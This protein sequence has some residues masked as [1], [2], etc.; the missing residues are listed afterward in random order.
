M[1]IPQTLL[2]MKA[3]YH[4]FNTEL[5]DT[6]RAQWFEKFESLFA[7]NTTWHLSHPL[8][9]V[10]GQGVQ[11]WN[12]H[13]LSPFLHAF[14]DAERHD[15]ILMAGQFTG[16]DW[17]AATGYYTATF[18]N[19]WCGIKPN[20]GVVNIRYGE[21]SRIENDRIVEVYCIFDML[22]VI[23]QAGQWPANLPNS[24]G[25]FAFAFHDRVPAPATRNGIDLNAAS[26][27]AG[28][29]SLTLVEA[30]IAGL[31]Q[32]DGKSLESMGME[33]FWHPEMMWY[34]PAGI[35][36]SRRLKGFQDVHQRDFLRAFP[37]RRGGNHKSRIGEGH[38]VAST[39][40]PSIRATHLGDWMGV[41]ASHRP[42]TMRVMD[43]WRRD[44][45]LLRE[46]WVFIDQLDLLLQMDVDVLGKLS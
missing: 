17:L 34:G 11:A 36:S 18:S 22:D 43:F 45:D 6:P 32:F 30:M 35:G 4:R 5:N 8:N 29:T 1:T 24:R 40:W 27:E 33:R 23:R 15:D 21:F 7:P 41:P 12:A 42:I 10:P 16:N 14:P 39:G 19:A 2:A 20:H 3:R 9:D 44:G 46:N 13:F 25:A 37:D 31:M 38:Y 26:D 28:R